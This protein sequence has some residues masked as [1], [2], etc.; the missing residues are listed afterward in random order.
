MGVARPICARHDCAPLR[1]KVRGLARSGPTPPG[2]A[3]D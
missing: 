1:R 3:D 2:L